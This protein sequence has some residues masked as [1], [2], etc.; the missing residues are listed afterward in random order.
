MIDCHFT[1]HFFFM[2]CECVVSGHC[3]RI[4]LSLYLSLG[5]IGSM[6]VAVAT[7]KVQAMMKASNE[8]IHRTKRVLCE[9]TQLESSSCGEV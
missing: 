9:T 8:P 7:I 5:S 4:E 2:K 1:V 6:T 3:V